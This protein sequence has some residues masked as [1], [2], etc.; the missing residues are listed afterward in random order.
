MKGAVSI[1]I[2][3][4][5]DFFALARALDEP[6]RVGVIDGERGGIAGCITVSCRQ[7]FVHG[8]PA[9]VVYVSDLKVCRGSRPDAADRLTLF[10]MDACSAFVGPRGLATF[11][12]LAGNRAMTRRAHGPRGL[13]T[14][15]LAGRLRTYSV[16]LLPLL[17]RPPKGLAIE[18]A[19]AG[20]VPEMMALWR[21]VA[22]QFQLAPVLAEERFRRWLALAPG[23]EIADYWV[24]RGTS[25]TLLGFV[26]LWNQES[27][28]QLRVMS[29]PHAVRWARHLF[30]GLAAATAN[31]RLPPR[32]GALGCVAAV[33]LCV[34]LDEP[35]VL[36]GLLLR[37]A[38]VLRRRF[39]VVNLSLDR[40]DPRAAALAGL[41]A[42]STDVDL[43]VSTASG[44]YTSAPL[45]GRLFQHEVALV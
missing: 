43:Y 29:Y 45:D 5:P 34:P 10:A 38:P 13:P 35:G 40:R 25:G 3:R 6:F 37:A 33:H 26:G 39:S 2:E 30:N 4:S 14:L 1:R 42:A 24:A 11:T 36:R 41:F 23:L 20:D 31:A 44:A 21:V 27:F 16:P 22:P 32:G 15:T 8:S 7:L 19:C 28:R 18:P 9:D 17:P 12:V